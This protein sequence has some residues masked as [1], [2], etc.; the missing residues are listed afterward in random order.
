MRC[1]SAAEL[2]A[3][4]KRVERDLGSPIAAESL[5]GQPPATSA[6]SPRR[7]IRR[8][9]R[10]LVL[11][12][13]V[14]TIAL[15]A[16]FM[17]RLNHSRHVYEP[18]LEGMKISQLT[19]TGN[20]TNATLSPDAK[21]VSYVTE[22]G[23]KSSIW[24]RQIV[25]PG[26]VQIVPPTETPY[27]NPTFSPDGTNIYYVR[28]FAG[29]TFGELYRVPAL[30]GTPQRVVHDIDSSVTFSPDAR[31][32]A[33]VRNRPAAPPLEST[34]LLITANADGSGERVLAKH[35]MPGIFSSPAWSPDGKNIACAIDAFPPAFYRIRVGYA[36]LVLV[37][38]ET[39]EVTPMAGPKWRDI[40]SLAWA[41]DGSALV[42]SGESA[43]SASGM[44][45]LWHLA[46]PSGELT[47]ISNDLNDY[48]GI[49][50]A[51]GNLVAVE[52]A[53][54]SSLYV[55]PEDDSAQ[56]R[57]VTSQVS[58]ADGAWGMDWTPDN[59]LVYTSGVS[60]SEDLWIMAVDGSHTMQLTANAGQ[61]IWPTV[62]PDGRSMFFASTRADGKLTIW[63]MNLEGGETKQLTTVPGDGQ[64]RVS[65]DERWLIYD[66]FGAGSRPTIMKLS[67]SGGPPTAVG[68]GHDIFPT[69]SFDGNWIAFYQ[70]NL[71][72]GAGMEIAIMR[73]DGGSVQK[74]FPEPQGTE[75]EAGLAWSRDNRAL[76]YVESRSGVDNI[77]ALPILGGAPR[78]L[79]HF[80]SDHIFNFA[81]SRQGNQL[82]V[83]RGTIS[84][85]V[86]LINFH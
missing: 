20:V 65:P 56:A 41:D 14:L 35:T 50:L 46:Y 40:G 82:A 85:D 62:S 71:V 53:L 75:V 33:F 22:D 37:S 70:L 81:F 74:T 8:F 51:S 23:G 17:Q 27:D 63:R 30:G 76:L 25:T 86:V 48:N 57:P 59:R 12:A 84:S 13:A 39:G 15:V 42:L 21:Y 4:L 64:P 5:A 77:F 73:F 16:L 52:S 69:L 6:R 79:T 34:S 58:R 61:N 3:D 10:L 72:Q 2:H 83:A 55:M 45:Q 49:A 44:R 67:L 32:I 29:E 80:E 19:T 1:Q 60:G 36:E 68:E 54:H 28:L 47:R 43:T 38:A 66:S 31:H 11:G 26:A 24:L 78:Q 18:S 9:N 7:G